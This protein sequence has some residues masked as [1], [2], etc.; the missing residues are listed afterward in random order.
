MAENLTR[1]DDC[2]FVIDEAHHLPDIVRSSS[3]VQVSIGGALEWL[4]KILS[5]S[6]KWNHA[7]VV[8]TI[9]PVLKATDAQ[10]ELT[11]SMSQFNQWA[12]LNRDKLFAE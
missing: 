11:A 5:S 9:Q 2:I 10:Q 6:T 3:A 8:M 1:L 4:K 7:L 12:T